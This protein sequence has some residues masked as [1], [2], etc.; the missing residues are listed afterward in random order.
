MPRPLRIRTS[1]ILRSLAFPIVMLGLGTACG[2][3][4]EFEETIVDQTSIPGGN[5]QISGPFSPQ[6]MGGF[7]GVDL[8]KSRG[9]QNN[10]VS[11]NDVD[12]IFVKAIRVEIATGSQNATLD[13]LD[14]FIERLELWVETNEQDRATLA[15]QESFPMT[16]TIDLTVDKSLNLKPYATSPA[17]T[18]GADLRLAEDRPPFNATM[19]TS[20]TLLVDINFFGT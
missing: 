20:I 7:N 5:M 14:N 4:D 6:F 9:F 13:R 11:P 17:M 16:R 18:I 3:L 2:A 10:D 19:T 12:A 15:V 8:S 1:P